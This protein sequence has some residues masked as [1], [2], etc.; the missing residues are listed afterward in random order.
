MMVLIM[1]DDAP[2]LMDCMRY[3]SL[4]EQLCDIATRVTT[5]LSSKFNC[6]FNLPSKITIQM[7]IDFMNSS[8]IIKTNSMICI[9]LHGIS[10]STL[11]KT[12]L[13][14]NHEQPGIPL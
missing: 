3:C 12:L 6:T 8:V 14:T 1:L 13:I 11:T 2:L 5:Q 10:T 9:G 7:Q 4:G